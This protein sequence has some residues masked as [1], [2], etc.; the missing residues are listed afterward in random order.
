MLGCAA[1]RPVSCV[2]LV[3]CTAEGPPSFL[4]SI[5]NCICCCS[6]L[7]LA[8]QKQPLLF[9][10]LTL[11][12]WA[13]SEVKSLS[14]PVPASLFLQVLDVVTGDTGREEKKSGWFQ[15]NSVENHVRLHCSQKLHGW[16]TSQVKAC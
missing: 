12:P 3:A 16:F 13:D 11:L 7:R 4:I 8:V 6:S 9:Q 14:W 2:C 15:E 1:P 5:E 10:V